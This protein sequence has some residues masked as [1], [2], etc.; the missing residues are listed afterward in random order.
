MYVG[1]TY[2]LGELQNAKNFLRYGNINLDDLAPYYIKENS[3]ANVDIKN[4]LSF[5]S[6]VSKDYEETITLT[7]SVTQVTTT[8]VIKS[9]LFYGKRDNAIYKLSSNKLEQDE[10]NRI[11]ALVMSISNANLFSNVFG[12]PPPPPDDFDPYKLI[13]IDANYLELIKWLNLPLVKKIVYPRPL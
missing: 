2:G 10:A 5:P 3:D 1:M 12:N 7:D 9:K 4:P 13:L 6:E 8:Q 11:S